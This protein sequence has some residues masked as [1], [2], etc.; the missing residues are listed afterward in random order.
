MVIRPC[1]WSSIPPVLPRRNRTLMSATFSSRMLPSK[2]V[3]LLYPKH[4]LNKDVGI[5]QNRES[6]SIRIQTLCASQLGWS[7]G[8]C[9]QASFQNSLCPFLPFSHRFFKV[10]FLVVFVFSFPLTSLYYPLSPTATPIFDF[11]ITK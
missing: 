2:L 4:F 5:F 1:F 8:S 6:G 9:H 3:L 11:F 7:S 10:C